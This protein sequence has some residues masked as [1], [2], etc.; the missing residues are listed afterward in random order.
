MSVSFLAPFPVRH[1][2]MVDWLRATFGEVSFNEVLLAGV[3][4]LCVGLYSWAPQAGQI[5]G[6]WFGGEG[7]ADDRKR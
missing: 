4:F 2:Q 7:D 3:F 1:K 6:G 5:I